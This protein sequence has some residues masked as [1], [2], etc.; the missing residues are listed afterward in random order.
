MGIVADGDGVEQRGFINGNI[1]PRL[2][3]PVQFTPGQPMGAIALPTVDIVEGGGGGSIPAEA[4]S[5]PFRLDGQPDGTYTIDPY[6]HYPVR[7]EALEG[8]TGA[9]VSVSPT[10]GNVAEIGDAIAI[11]V[12]GSA[13]GTPVLGTLL[14]RRVG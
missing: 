1:Q 8:V 7:I 6:Q 4:E 9:T 14:L 10:V 2:G 11:T 3:A 5:F 12:S 13:S